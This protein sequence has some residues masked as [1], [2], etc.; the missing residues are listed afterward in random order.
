MRIYLDL[1]MG[2]NFLVDFLLLLGTDRLSG[3]GSRWYRT[4]TASALG[5]VYGGVCFLPDFRFLANPLWRVVSLALMGGIAFGFC[6]SAVTRCGIFALLSMALG[7]IAL[8][9][10]RS[11]WLALPLA[12][13]VLWLLCRTGLQGSRGQEYLPLEIRYGENRV[14]LT[15]LRDTGNTLRDPV[16]GEK[17]LVISAT[18]AEKLTGLTAS[19]IADPI[20]TLQGQSLPGLRLIPYRAVGSSGMLLAMRFSDVCLGSH[21]QSAVVAFAPEGL[22]ENSAFQALTGGVV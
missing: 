13:G 7:G 3:Y 6:R 4:V 15:A 21:N 1:V 2:L 10:G 5:G 11:D 19:Q 9:M 16:T 14:C 8:A 17:V 20:K 22:G 12:G 18:A